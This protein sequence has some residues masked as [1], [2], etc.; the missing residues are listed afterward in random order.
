M[1]LK[2][3]SQNNPVKHLLFHTV[4]S[5]FW[6]PVVITLLTSCVFVLTEV[7]S[8]NRMLASLNRLNFNGTY[9][10]KNGEIWELFP[11]FLMAISALSAYVTFS[12]LFK[13]KSATMMM[14]T[15]VSR[16]QLFS[17]KYLFGLIS[18][19]VPSVVF[20]IVLLGIGAGNVGKTLG[21]TS[22]NNILLVL[23]IAAIVVYSYTVA[24]IAASL[25]G[26]KT[27]F[28]VVCGVFYF[29][30]QGLLLFGTMII[31]SFLHGFAFP[32]RDP[33]SIPHSYQDIFDKFSSLSV[34]TIFKTA[35]DDYLY[36]GTAEE[37]TSLNVYTLEL[38]WLWVIA[39]LLIPV[40]A[41]AFKKRNSEYDGKP[42]SGSILSVVSTIIIALAVSSCV[43]LYG[44]TAKNMLISALLF[45]VVSLVFHG[46]FEGTFRKVL[47]S[48][49]YALPALGSACLFAMIVYADPF[50]YSSKIP[51]ISEVESVQL[52]Y[53]GD[54][55]YFTCISMGSRNGI[56]TT[57]IDFGEVPVFTSESDIKKAMDIHKLLIEDGSIFLSDDEDVYSNNVVY[58]DYFVIYKL[59]DGTELMR[60]YP[61][62]KLSTLYKTL[63]AED[64]ESFTK[65]IEERIN[66]AYQQNYGGSSDTEKLFGFD[67]ALS[68]NMAANVSAVE[69]TLEEKID[70]FKAIAKDKANETAEQ[71]YHPS[72]E[73]VGVIWMDYNKTEAITPY[74]PTCIYKHNTETLAWLENKG[75][76]PLFEKEYTV[77]SIEL[78]GYDYS[79][80]HVNDQAN[81]RFFS[82]NY[83]DRDIS[84]YIHHHINRV[85]VSEAE[86][87]SVL[88]NSRLQYFA[89]GGNKYA[90]IT[91]VNEK[92]ETI[93]TTKYIVE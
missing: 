83:N 3:Y 15:G 16:V 78:F 90:M 21:F 87:E 92:G 50:G 13:K 68:D 42:N 73:C 62:M 77:K 46:F 33:Y 2:A 57:D 58:S 11:Y 14:L 79:V 49:K 5:F 47:K 20:F 61:K 67:V 84:L 8:D 45:L 65:Y 22:E 4:K 75:I 89:D 6:L 7:I 56:R 32:V 10:F 59:K 9:I 74:T 63:E 72:E 17:V 66:S 31:G 54:Y 85:S 70:L 19:L 35:L 52:S 40:A 82:C 36:A 93:V 27:E 43:L 34:N 48:M 91:L 37:P 29:G 30:A 80:E 51:D 86:F 88:K 41:V 12:F 71:K 18:A 76:L 81:D 38:T 25:C 28:F 1:K 23:M 39:L 69:L 26:R 53:K 60:S 24:V 64:T 55:N 44:N